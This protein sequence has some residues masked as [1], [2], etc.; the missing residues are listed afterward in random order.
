[1]RGRET[2]GEQAEAYQQHW[3]I[4]RAAHYLGM[5]EAFIRKAVRN[6]RIPFYRVGSKALRFRK[7]A[8]DSWLEMNGPGG[9][10]SYG[11]KAH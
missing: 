6:R 5:S 4:R 9:E 10:V 3:N 1:M 2:Q 8:L 7:E 11:D